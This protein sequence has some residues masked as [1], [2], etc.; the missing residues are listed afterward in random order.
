VFEETLRNGVYPAIGDMN[1]GGFAGLMVGA[2]PGGAPRTIVLSGA[3]L[4][5][6]NIGPALASPLANLFAGDPANRS[7]VRVAA[8]DVDGDGRAELV[9]GAADG[10]TRAS[11]Y[12]LGPGG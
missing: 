11:V 2:G 7:G 8:V 6:A 3:V 1:G 4:T 9:S 12:K 5:S 10:P